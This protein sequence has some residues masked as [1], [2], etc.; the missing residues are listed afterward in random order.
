MVIQPV[1]DLERAAIVS[2]EALARFATEPDR[3]PSGQGSF[4]GRPEPLLH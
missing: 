3:P 2:F 1:F 4:L